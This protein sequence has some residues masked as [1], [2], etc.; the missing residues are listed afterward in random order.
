MF[1]GPFGSQLASP[2]HWLPKSSL[3][4]SCLPL[5]SIACLSPPPPLSALFQPALHPGRLSCVFTAMDQSPCSLVSYGIQIM[6]AELEEDWREKG[7][8]LSPHSAC[9]L[10]FFV[11]FFFFLNVQDFIYLSVEGSSGPTFF[12]FSYLKEAAT[13]FYFWGCSQTRGRR[14]KP[15]PRNGPRVTSVCQLTHRLTAPHSF[16]YF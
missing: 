2:F 12:Y 5:Q 6:R 8:E 15:F 7:E 16:P 3:W 9:T 14:D 4:K 13:Q 11:L 1:L 10:L